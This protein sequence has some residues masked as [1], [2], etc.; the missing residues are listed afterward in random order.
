M[1]S[2]YVI[3]L[4]P[5]IAVDAYRSQVISDQAALALFYSNRSVEELLEANHTAAVE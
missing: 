4:N 2:A 5:E 3:D 1:D